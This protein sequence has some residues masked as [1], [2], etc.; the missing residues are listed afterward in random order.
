[1]SKSIIVAEQSEII[2]KGLV[3]LVEALGLFRTIREVACAS[4]LDENIERFQP[5]VLILNPSMVSGNTLEVLKEKQNG[6]IKIAAIV[7]ALFDDELMGLFDDVIMVSDTRQKIQKKI[8]ALLDKTPA[9]KNQKPEETLSVRELDV[10]KLLVKGMSNKEISD[11]LFISIHT[12]ISHR[13]NITQKLNIKSVA[14][15]TVYAILNEI[16]SMDEVQ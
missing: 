13:K 7:Y 8:N 6:E 9:K 4:A 2:R 3:Y 10:L 11:K 15:L 14:G 12:V 5:D 1:M 16:I